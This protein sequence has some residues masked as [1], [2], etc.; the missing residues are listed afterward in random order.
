MSL[1]YQ[2]IHGG[3]SPFISNITVPC[4]VVIRFLPWGAAG[5]FE[6]TPQQ[7]WSSLQILRDLPDDTLVCCA[8]EY[9][10]SNGLFA[11][12]VDPD[13]Q[14]LVD[15]MELVKA[16]REQDM[17]TVPSQMSEEKATN[18]FLRADN[19]ALQAAIGMTGRD[20]VDVFAEIRRQKDTF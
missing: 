11:L 19:P 12:S 2:A 10:L 9:T 18:P 8:H 20:S 6:G 4:F 15:R 3:I 17:A 13:N 1:M 14:A 5:L 7:M 16:A